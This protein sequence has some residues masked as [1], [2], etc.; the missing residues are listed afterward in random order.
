MGIN[1]LIFVLMPVSFD[2][3][4][5]TCLYIIVHDTGFLF[6]RTASPVNFNKNKKVF[7]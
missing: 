4:I 7:N 3:F 2:S 1:F 5:G 6:V